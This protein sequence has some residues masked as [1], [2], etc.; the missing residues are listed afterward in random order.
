M[1]LAGWLANCES[2]IIYER[3]AVSST[4]C[5]THHIHIGQIGACAS[6]RDWHPV[7]T[8]GV[9]WPCGHGDGLAIVWSSVRALPARIRWRPRGVVWDSVPESMVEYIK[10]NP[11]ID[12]F[13]HQIRNG[14][15]G[16]T[17]RAHT[18]NILKSWWKV[19][20]KYVPGAKVRTGTY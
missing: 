15:Q 10:K 13:Y 16:C 7:H 18:K 20:T 11:F 12:V 14:I 8:K 19:C 3:L 6:G 17:T 4:V 5:Y 9:S 1:V 2:T